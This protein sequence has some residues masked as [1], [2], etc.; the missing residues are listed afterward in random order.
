MNRASQDLQHHLGILLER[1]LHPTDYEKALHYFLEEFAGDAPFIN[2]SNQVSAPVLGAVLRSIIK[3][4]S[5][6]LHPFQPNKIMRCEGHG[7]HHGNGSVD[8]RVV[9]FF[10]F[11]SVNKG[12]AAIIPGFT[13]PVDVA[14]FSLPANLPVDASRN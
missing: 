1:L 6:K 14:R 8:D 2:G 7:F 5:G 11:E 9:L 12:L 13:G 3:G 4:A 10:H